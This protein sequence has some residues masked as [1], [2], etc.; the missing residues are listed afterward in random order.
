MFE[1]H[2]EFG[3][4]WAQ[5]ANNMP[6]RTDNTIKNHFHSTLRRQLGKINSVLQSVEMEELSEQKFNETTLEE[7]SKYLKDGVVGKLNA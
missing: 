2:R 7:L 3:N 5:I 6:G 1:L 4:K